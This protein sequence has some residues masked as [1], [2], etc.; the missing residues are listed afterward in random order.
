MQSYVQTIE[1]LVA[2]KTELESALNKSQELA[3][4]K[5]SKLIYLIT[6]YILLLFF[7][8]NIFLKVNVKKF[9]AI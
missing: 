5:T 3:K 4:N 2:E 8:I 9:R 1:I 7:L 6:L